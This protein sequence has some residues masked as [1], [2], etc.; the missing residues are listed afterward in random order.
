MSSNISYLFHSKIRGIYVGEMKWL[1]VVVFIYSILFC[2]T[3]DAVALL[4]V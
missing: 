3:Y 4:F 2:Y 1:H